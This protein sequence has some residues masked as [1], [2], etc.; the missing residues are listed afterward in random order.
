MARVDY[1]FA[2]AE[3]WDKGVFSVPFSV[4]LTCVSKAG[5]ALENVSKSQCL[6]KSLC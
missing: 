6:E 3:Y 5:Q 2:I 1:E 4:L